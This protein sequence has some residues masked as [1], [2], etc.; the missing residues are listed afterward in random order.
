[1]SELIA[2]LLISLCLTIFTGVP[3]FVLGMFYEANRH[4]W[5]AEKVTK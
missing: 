5:R 1:M 3:F 4:R 2:I